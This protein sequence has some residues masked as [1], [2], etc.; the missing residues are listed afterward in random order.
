MKALGLWIR[1]RSIL[2]WKPWWNCKKSGRLVGIISH[3]PELKGRIPAHLVVEATNKG[4]YGSLFST[5]DIRAKKMG[6]PMRVESDTSYS[7][8]SYCYFII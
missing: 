2:P 3:V 5:V 4:Q 6:S 7:S 1:I 8:L